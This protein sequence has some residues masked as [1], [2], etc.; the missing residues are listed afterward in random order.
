MFVALVL[1]ILF[2]VSGLDYS[3]DRRVIKKIYMAHIYGPY[4]MGVQLA[5]VSWTNIFGSKNEFDIKF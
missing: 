2:F 1:I 4:N 5:R 3:E